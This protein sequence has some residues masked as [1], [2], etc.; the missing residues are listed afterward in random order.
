MTQVRI[1]PLT[2]IHPHAIQQ[3]EAGLHP[4]WVFW[5]AAGSLLLHRREKAKGRL[6][7]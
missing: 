3:K 6:L 1:A 4:V 7:F 2:T 5:E